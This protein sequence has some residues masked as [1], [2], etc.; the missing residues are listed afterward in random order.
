V[1]V[2]AQGDGRTFTVATHGE[3]SRICEVVIDRVRVSA[4]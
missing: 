4:E 2:R 1:C 3:L